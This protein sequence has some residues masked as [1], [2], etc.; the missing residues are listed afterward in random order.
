MTS[1]RLL[2]TSWAA[3][4]RQMAAQTALEALLGEAAVKSTRFRGGLGGGSLERA[5]RLHYLRGCRGRSDGLE[6]LR[7][8]PWRRN[9]LH[10][11]VP[12]GAAC[13]DPRPPTTCIEY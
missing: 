9:R 4:G 11:L 13:P 1:W 7:G 8:P 5:H 2:A 10:Y 3:V 6:Y 12:R